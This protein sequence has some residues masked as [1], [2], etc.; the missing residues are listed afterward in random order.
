VILP[1]IKAPRALPRNVVADKIKA[2]MTNGA[3]KT[4]ALKNGGTAAKRITIQSEKLPHPPGGA[5]RLKER[6]GAIR[7]AQHMAIEYE[8]DYES[9]C[10]LHWLNSHYFEGV[11]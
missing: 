5:L 4:V 10:A 9:A 6:S 3:L 1:A 11:K 2:S 8:A 7:S